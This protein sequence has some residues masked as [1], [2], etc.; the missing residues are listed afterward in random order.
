MRGD[1]A[2]GSARAIIETAAGDLRREIEHHLGLGYRL[3]LVAAHHDAGRSS[4]DA[5]FRVVYLLVKGPPDS[6]VELHLRL[7]AGKPTVPS[8]AELSFPASRFEREMRDLFGIE[9]E[10]HPQPA[11]LALHQ[12][13]PDRW[14]PMRADA[15]P[16]PPFGDESQPFPF[17]TV[18]GPGV[19]EIPVGPVHAGLIEPGH[20]RFSVVG[21]TILTMRA[22]LWFVHKGVERLFQG[23]RPAAGLELAERVSGDTAVGHALAYCLAVEEAMGWPV[24][25]VAQAGRALLLELERLYNHVADIGALCNDVGFGIVNAHALRIRERLLRLN[26]EVTGHRLLRGAVVPGGVTLRSLPAAAALEAIAGDAGDLVAIAL[27]N[28]TVVD[29]FTG[30]AVLTAEQAA[31]IGTVGYVARGSGLAYDARHAHP[32][33]D[34]YRDLQVPV[35]QRGDVMARFSL[36]VAE[37]DQS[38]ALACR[39]LTEAES[40]VNVGD[41]PLR[42]GGQGHG[43]GLVEG[44]RGTIS[45]R[46]ELGVDG[47]LTRVKVVDPS[48][49]NWPALPVAL[50]DTIVPDFPLANKSFNLS[51]AGNDL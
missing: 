36:R 40:G 44:W 35:Q 41:E 5:H 47:G 19:Y 27:A 32:H 37:L 25:P 26:A 30:T 45:H 14:H 9:P 17:L 21:E 4:S 6:R 48:F 28:S 12:H 22:R 23:R 24:P 18:E 1:G 43:V 34:L 39:L 46:V 29:R 33:A 15:G 7:S 10:D 50:A 8:L 11:R 2:P 20:F 42:V 51:Y 3:A 13:W 16:A 49:L 38:V 31:E